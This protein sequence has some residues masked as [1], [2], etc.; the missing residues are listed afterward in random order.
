MPCGFIKPLGF[1]PLSSVISNGEL[2][3]HPFSQKS[4]LT[5]K[6]I[7][8]IYSNKEHIYLY[9][10]KNSLFHFVCEKMMVGFK[11]NISKSKSTP[12]NN[13]FNI[14][15]RLWIRQH[16]P[17]QTV[18]HEAPVTE[19]QSRFSSPKWNMKTKKEGIRC[20]DCV[21]FYYGQRIYLGL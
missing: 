5:P 18:C 4:L 7:L 13:L 12:H 20:W 3:F 14:N 21:W 11:G 15:W 10:Y 19:C 1:K 6:M 9:N 8:S 2:L 17:Y 16:S